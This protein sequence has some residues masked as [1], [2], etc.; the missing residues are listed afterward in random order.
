MSVTCKG[1]QKFKKLAVV[2][3]SKL[4][5][6]FLLNQVTKLQAGQDKF[7]HSKAL[8][9]RPCKLSTNPTEIMSVPSPHFP[10]LLTG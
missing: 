10:T 6:L 5:L 8:V 4:K 9:L 3:W 1:K 2:T 7:R